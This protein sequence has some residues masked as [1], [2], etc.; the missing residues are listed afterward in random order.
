MAGDFL[1]NRHYKVTFLFDESNDWLKEYI[2]ETDLLQN[3]SVFRFQTSSNPEEVVNQDLV[4]ILGYTHLLDK[5]FLDKNKL[6]LVVHE[7]DLPQGKGF[8]PVQWQIL[9]GKNRIPICLFEATEQIDSGDIL[10][11][12]YFTLSGYE[13]YDQIRLVQAKA[14][15][16]IIKDF[17]KFYPTYSKEKQGLGETYYCRRTEKDSELDVDK[18][19][20]E[21]FNLLRIGNNDKW[22][23][24]FFIDGKKYYLRIYNE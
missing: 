9:A 5:E 20:Q 17:L 2:A 4:F 24:Y 1:S 22:P 16:K 11:K 19:I 13:L 21:Q 14:T 8:S 3:N 6:N 10:L 15:H 7:S 23:S 12:Q 18:S